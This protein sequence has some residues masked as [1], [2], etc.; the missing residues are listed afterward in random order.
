MTFRLDPASERALRELTRDGTSRSAAIRDALINAA[1]ARSQ[2]RLHD[3]AMALAADRN[4]VEE[5]HRVLDDTE[6]L[7]ECVTRRRFSDR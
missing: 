3:E 2:Q 4:D 5:M 1:R 7:R 6:S